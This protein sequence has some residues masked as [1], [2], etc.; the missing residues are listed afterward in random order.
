MK[1]R[2]EAMGIKARLMKGERCALASMRLGPQPFPT[3]DGQVRI[4][5][6][7]FSTV[8]P[9]RIK[10]L[11][12]RALFQLPLL[13]IIDCRDAMSIEARIRVAWQSHLT[14]LREART[15]LTRMGAV[16][17][18]DQEQSILTFQLSG[19][20][21]GVRATVVEP[22]RVILPGRGPLSG[23][24]LTRPEDRV[25]TPDPGIDSSSDLEIAI[26]NRLSELRRM[27]QRLAQERRNAAMLAAPPDL[28]DETQP[29]Q[30][31]KGHRPRLL[32]VGSSF[33]Q[34]RACLESLRLRGY[35]VASART[36][37]AAIALLAQISPELVMVD[38]QLGR[39]EGIELIPALRQVTGIEELPVILVDSHRRAMRREAARRVG[40]AGYLVRPI[41][42]PRIAKRLERMITEPKRRRFTRYS[43]RIPVRTALARGSWLATSVGRGGMF[44]A[45]EED[46][47][48]RSVHTCELNLPELGRTLSV[49]AEVLYRVSASGESGRGVGMR[50][51][52]FHDGSEPLF[53]SYLAALDPGA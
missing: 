5:N 24:T 52:R 21:E 14:K 44:V 37:V 19:E 40:A 47:P 23:V 12:P 42:V 39:S 36:Q 6:V 30:R 10:C 50:F 53:I 35:E 18:A 27:D 4:A 15:W 41:D 46:V 29:R 8:G 34:E 17:D 43:R 1:E 48:T 7:V 13:R 45:T 38:V 16:A 33:T 25:M 31:T 22:R 51:H 28:S 9:D 32:L 3:L 20:G 49:D 11:R 26:S 2:L